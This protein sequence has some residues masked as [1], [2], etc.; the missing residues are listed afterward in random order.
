[1]LN[2][3]RTCGAVVV[4]RWYGGQNIGPIRFTH[5]EASAR[6]AIRNANVKGAS[7]SS[8][9]SLPSSSSISRV[10]P[11]PKK[12][13]GDTDADAA[14]QDAK[15]KELAAALQDRDYNISAL[16][17]L[18]SEK[19]ARLQG[20]E[21][22]E[23]VTPQK[24]LDYE[25]M[26]LDALVRLDKARDATVAFILKQIDKVDEEMKLVEALEGEDGEEVVKEAERNEEESTRKT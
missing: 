6:A 9:S 20:D 19:K 25:R 7:Y 2:D 22:A 15:R 26:G 18:L 13:K 8:S 14:A 24:S 12:A 5:I 17:K 21:E 10:Q 11:S 1:M 4:A 23:V 16:R 3:T